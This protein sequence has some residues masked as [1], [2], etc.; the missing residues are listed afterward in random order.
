MLKIILLQ[1]FFFGIISSLFAQ[2]T[3]FWE[4][5][6]GLDG[7]VDIIRT[8]GNDLIVGGLFDSVNGDSSMSHI[9]KWSGSSW[10][11]LGIGTND[12]VTSVA[13]DSNDI[14]VGGSFTSAGGQ[15][16]TGFIARW[17][18]TNWNS[19]GSG[20]NL[21]VSTL[22]MNGDSLYVGGAF[23]NAGGNPDADK[24]A[25]WN[26]SNWEAMDKG[27]NDWVYTI[28]I[29]NGKIY[30][31]GNFTAAGIDTSVKFIAK[32]NNA[33]S[34]WE[35]FGNGLNSTVQHI[36]FNGDEMYIGGFFTDAGGDPN[37][38]HI[39]KWNGTGWEG[40]GPGLNG[41]FSEVQEFTFDGGDMYVVGN[42]NVAGNDSTFFNIAKW[43][44]STWEKM[45][46]GVDQEARSLAILDND[47]YIGGSFHSEAPGGNDLLFIAKHPDVTS[48]VENN[49]NT[50]PQDFTL[51]QNYPNPFNPS[52]KIKYTI[53][54]VTL[55]GVEGSRVQLIVYDML[56][57]E[58]ATLV[59]EYKPAGAYEVEF[60]ASQLSSGVY[61]YQL[62]AGE[63][64]ETK[65][66]ILM[67]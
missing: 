11:P 44:G 47:L 24:I 60:N 66:L 9:A 64:I 10:E 63:F 30:A 18:G 36:G 33:N 17:D 32:W 3:G 38:D 37:A 6:P 51:F 31:G 29:H 1:I 16:N 22:L 59:D 27:F 61:F 25:I 28:A 53:T 58:V 46:I 62:K 56:G 4:P 7:A 67:K 19:L 39:A 15:S 14:Y 20:L 21:H 42:F 48:D 50:R 45:G 40:I 54:N 65:K 5:I 55:S 52:T 49:L 13:F 23:R 43:N 12:W 57:N 26:G 34:N 2:G 35:P 8:N 41:Q